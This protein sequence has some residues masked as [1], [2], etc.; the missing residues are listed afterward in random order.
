MIASAMSL[1]RM[2]NRDLRQ[3]GITPVVRGDQV[4]LTEETPM[5]LVLGDFFTILDVESDI[6]MAN[7]REPLSSVLENKL[8]R[9]EDGYQK[10]QNYIDHQKKES[11]YEADQKSGQFEEVLRDLN[12]IQV[13]V[14]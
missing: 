8:S 7:P 2:A 6:K 14:K 4:F 1:E 5:F 9:W 11:D 3:R 12:K 10:Y 13:Q